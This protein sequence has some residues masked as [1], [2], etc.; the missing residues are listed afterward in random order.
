[1]PG[2]GAPRHDL[3][4]T[5]QPR[6]SAPAQDHTVVPDWRFARSKRHDVVR[7]PTSTAASPP[8]GCARLIK[9]PATKKERY[10]G[11]GFHDLRRANATGLVLAGVDLKTAQ[12][13]LGHSD[14]R[15]TIGLYAQATSHADKAAA[16]AMGA[17]FSTPPRDG[18]GIAGAAT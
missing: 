1:M 18:R 17:H 9:D 7:V 10:E 11:A 2:R 16:D 15:M 14:P 6:P 3:T 5:D 13:R 4:R 12:T 8:D